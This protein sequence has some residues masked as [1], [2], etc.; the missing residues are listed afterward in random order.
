MRYILSDLDDEYVR[1]GIIQSNG[2]DCPHCGSTSG[3]KA[4]CALI[5]A[6]AKQELKHLEDL[7]NVKET[8]I[9]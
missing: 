6:E 2:G 7:Y 3:H 4:H 8:T 1:V 5:N 9:G